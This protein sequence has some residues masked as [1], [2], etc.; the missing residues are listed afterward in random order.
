MREIALRARERDPEGNE[1][2]D[3]TIP[4]DSYRLTAAGLPPG[5][6]LRVTATIAGNAVAR[7]FTADGAGAIDQTVQVESPHMLAA[8]PYIQSA[9]WR[10][11]G[12]RWQAGAGDMVIVVEIA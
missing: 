10:D 11:N 8:L 6:T 1:R 7:D 4:A 9:V 12:S 3:A 2:P 5:A